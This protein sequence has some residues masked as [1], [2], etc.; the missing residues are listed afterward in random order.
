[1]KKTEKF[2]FI[3]TK[4][5]EKPSGFG[6]FFYYFYIHSTN[7]RSLTGQTT[8]RHGGSTIAEIGNCLRHVSLTPGWP[9]RLVG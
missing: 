1:V 6:I 2:V 7:S 9:S 8:V 5:R 4:I 3:N